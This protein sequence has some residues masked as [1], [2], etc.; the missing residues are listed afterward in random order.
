MHRHMSGSAGAAASAAALVLALTA[1]SG[2]GSD[3]KGDTA[4]ASGAISLKSAQAVL[5]NYV[6]VNNE[7]NAQHDADKMRLVEHGALLEQS[8]A[9]FTQFPALSKKEQAGYQVPFYYPV[10]DAR[11]YIPRKGSANF[12]MVDARITGKGIEKDRRRLITFKRVTGETGAAWKAASVGE[13]NDK[14]PAVQRDGDGFVTALQASDKV[15]TTKL[16]DLRE[17][18]RDFYETGGKKAGSRF[19]VTSAV[20]DWKKAY[21]DRASFDDKCVDGKYENGFSAAETA[22]GLKT[23]DGGAIVQY[24][25]GIDYRNWPKADGGCP[26]IELNLNDMPK[27]TKIYLGGRTTTIGLTRTDAH[28][29]T[30]VVPPSGERVRVTGYLFQMVNA[31]G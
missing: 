26:G 15:G 7:A 13:L 9:T 22:Y 17:L 4:A 25:F 3:G 14:L 12:F 29:V 2:S 1:C 19:A 5:L 11:F 31:K 10:K 16:D 24:D 30:A 23:A 21:E 6:K 27:V 8:R 18:S 28:I 20:K